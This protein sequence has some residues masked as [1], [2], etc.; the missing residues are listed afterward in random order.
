VSARVRILDAARRLVERED[1]GAITMGHLARQAQVSRQSVYN[2][3]G[4]KAGVADALV[5]REVETFLVT[6]EEQISAGDSPADSATRA[7]QAVFA[8]AA[9]NPVVSAAVT[10]A[11]GQPSALLPL[12]TSAALIDAVVLRA[13]TA[14][15]TRHPIAP[16]ELR[17]AVEAIV[18]L[19]ISHIV[20]P[21]SPPD[22]AYVAA[23]LLPRT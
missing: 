10:A 8:S 11:G 9:A 3:F 14:M 1:W 5:G 15:C 7:C 6:V 2:E 13:E 17:P 12:L 18:R 19:T 16:E 20:S 23:R 4:S 22:M 21:G